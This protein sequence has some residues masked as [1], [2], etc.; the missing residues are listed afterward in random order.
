M[1]KIIHIMLIGVLS[2]LAFS[3]NGFLNRV[4]AQEESVEI[5]F[6]I[7]DWGVP[8][9]EMLDRFEEESGIK[10]NVITT[11]WDDIRDKVSTAAVGQTVAADVF[12]VDWS[13]TGEFVAADW[14]AP[15][16]VDEETIKD[17]PNLETFK[18]EDQY[19]AV[20]YANDFRISYV[21]TEMFDNAEIKELP[22]NWDQ[23]IEDAKII[24]EKGIVDYPISIP[25]LAE[26]NSTTTFIWLAFTRNG[27]VFNDD[28]TLNHEALVDTLTLIDTLVKEEL[29]NPAN[30]NISG[31]DAY[32]QIITG[33][34]AAM[35]GPSSFVT[36][37]NDEENSSVVGKVQPNRP[38]SK[39]QDYAQVTVP[40]NEA[41]GISKYTEYPEEALQ[42]VKW[43]T[44]PEIQEQLNKEISV[45]PTRLSV[46]EKLF[47][48]GTIE[49]GET[50][51]DIAEIAE[52]PFPKG[53]PEYYAEMSAAIFNGVNQLASGQLS[54]EEAT[55][56][57]ESTVN[58]LALE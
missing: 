2:M 25:L 8:T 29:V 22:T 42:F 30:T 1:R 38:L 15:I 54:V 36:R 7:P 17:I 43:Y 37:I 27:I 44:S 3:G 26:E 34:T 40:F 16:Q 56:E 57:I 58:D 20:P 51:Y 10:V 4:S 47:S 18:I 49:N 13:W 39:D 48:E 45:T 9:D 41:I 33:D 55:K 24:K 23:L 53:I 35:T 6:M 28:N 31:M 32:S 21:N 52:S 50:F 46:L 11:A 14:L 5:S 12:E 19:Y